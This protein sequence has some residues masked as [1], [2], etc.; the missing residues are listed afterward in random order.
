MDILRGQQTNRVR[1]H[2]LTGT[3]DEMIQR[4]SKCGFEYYYTLERCPHCAFPG[5]Y[6][7]VQIASQKSEVDAVDRRYDKAKRGADKRGCAQA[8]GDFTNW[9]Q[10]SRVVVARSRA[11][12]ERLAASDRSVQGTYYDLTDAGLVLPDGSLWEVLRRPADEV[13]FPSYREKIRFGALSADG[14]GV[15][16]YGHFWMTMR[17]DFIDERTTVFDQNS[18]TFVGEKRLKAASAS[19]QGHRGT[20]SNR[21][22]LAAAQ[23]AAQIAASTRPD[24]F[25]SILIKQGATTGTD[26]YIEAQ[27][28]GGVTVRT[29]E[30]VKFRWSLVKS[31][32]PRSLIKRLKIALDSFSTALVEA[33]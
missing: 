16:N 4:C 19:L 25:P 21:S 26:R 10:N 11:D 2:G 23:L 17:T 27:I 24:E 33:P 14:I 12:I 7:N 32:T 20:W 9:L 18:V 8:F 30:S 13:L 3:L 15:I 5:N 22:K 1:V 31:D 28:W 29:I 6:S